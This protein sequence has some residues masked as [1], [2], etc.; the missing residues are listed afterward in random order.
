MTD[1]E[2]KHVELMIKIVEMLTKEG[3]SMAEMIGIL[4]VSKASLISATQTNE[5]ND[6]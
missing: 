2:K 3:L 5:A 6:E 4:E 1:K